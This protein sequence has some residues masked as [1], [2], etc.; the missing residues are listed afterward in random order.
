MAGVAVQ[1]LPQALV[2]DELINISLFIC[3]TQI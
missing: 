1:L 2:V 3:F